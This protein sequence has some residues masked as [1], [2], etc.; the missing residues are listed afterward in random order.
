MQFKGEHV[1][2]SIDEDTSVRLLRPPWSMTC[3]HCIDYVL[4]YVQFLHLFALFTSFQ[5]AW[6][7]RA[8]CV[9]P[10]TSLGACGSSREL[11]R[12]E[13]ASI[14]TSVVAADR[15]AAVTGPYAQST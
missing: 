15:H 3:L 10:L 11:R 8:V 2:P 6:S 12:I 13:N 7:P 1:A 4:G 14:C 5:T 9:C